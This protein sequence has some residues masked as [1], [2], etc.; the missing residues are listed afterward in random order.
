VKRVIS[1]YQ[2][3]RSQRKTAKQQPKGAPGS[4]VAEAEAGK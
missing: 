3:L 2:Q 1:Y 4:V